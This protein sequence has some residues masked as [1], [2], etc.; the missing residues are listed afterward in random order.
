MPRGLPTPITGAVLRWAREEACLTP[1]ELAARLKVAPEL[2]LKWED[3]QE[4]PLR[5]QFKRLARVL[6]RPSAIFFLPEP[7]KRPSVLARFRQTDD[8]H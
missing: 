7:P 8:L 2:V 1:E 4:A 3:G 6:R 5:T